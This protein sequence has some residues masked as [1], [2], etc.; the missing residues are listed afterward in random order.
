LH[1]LLPIPDPVAFWS[2]RLCCWLH[3]AWVAKYGHEQERYNGYI[4]YDDQAPN[5]FQKN[6]ARLRAV[7][8]RYDP[9]NVFH[10]VLSVPAA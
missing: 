3:R 10:N 7:K 2:R 9:L 5:Y 6:Y 8:R 4:S 1:V